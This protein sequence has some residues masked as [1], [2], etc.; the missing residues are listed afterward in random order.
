MKSRDSFLAHY[1]LDGKQGVEIGGSA[2]NPFN[3][4]GCKNVDYTDDMTT[5]F[6]QHEIETCGEAMKVDIVADGAHLPFG[7]N[8]L[9]YIVSSHVIEHFY[10]PIEV[11]EHWMKIIRPGGYVFAIVPHKDRTF[12]SPRPCTTLEELIERHAHPD[13]AEAQREKHHS[14]WRTEDFLAL[15]KH[16]NLNVVSVQDIDDKVGNGFTVVIRK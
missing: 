16:L 3:I 2:H 10:D 14:V 15:C 1:F 8:S 12:D 4:P 7:E 9:D 5:I 13:I 6:K 11:L